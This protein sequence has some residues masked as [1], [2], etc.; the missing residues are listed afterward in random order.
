MSRSSLFKK[1]GFSLSGAAFLMATSAIGPGF[2]TQTTVFT[3]QLGASFAFAI[4]ASILLD[5]VVQLN[6]WQWVAL[7]GQKAP[8]LAATVS[9]PGAVL[10]SVMVL[11]GGLV[12]NMGNVAGCG[13]GIQSMVGGHALPGALASALL[14]IGL[15]LIKEFG[16]AM[17]RFA[18]WLGFL[19]IAMVCWVAVV[20]QPPLGQVAAQALW[21]DQINVPAILT[22]V[23]GTV[24]GYIS[25]A[26]AH[27][28]LESEGTNAA[29]QVTLAAVSGIVLSG[30]MRVGLFLA[31]LGVV[32]AGFVPAPD[33]PAASV[34]G[35]VLGPAGQWVFGLVLWCAAI[36]SVVGASYTSVSFIEH[37]HP[38]IARQRRWF[39]V[40][41]ILLS[42]AAFALFGK[43]V[44]VLVMAGAVNALVLPLA[45]LLLLLAARR[46]GLHSR[47]R[48]LAALGWLAV[49]LVGWLAV[50]VWRQL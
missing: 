34:F 25:F 16:Q 1:R 46:I 28:L 26:G 15:F 4:V 9:R 7:S 50:D 19:L 8:Q 30:I 42:S 47:H 5:I 40:G 37:W 6:I 24:G 14:A 10:L 11:L 36:T 3:A 33:N 12:F 20:S 27:R 21:P 23:G 22:L 48:W 45:L 38:F 32:A 41:F 18:R 13:L 39:I 44:N 2:I 43:P 49:L 17:D 35:Q 29:R 31:V